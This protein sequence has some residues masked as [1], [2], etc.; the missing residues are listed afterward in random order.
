MSFH[1]SEHTEGVILGIE[2]IL[3]VMQESDSSLV[4][5]RDIAIGRLIAAW[6][7]VVQEW[8]PNEVEE[9]EGEFAGK[10]KLFRKRKIKDNEKASSGELVSFMIEK[11][12]VT[13]AKIFTKDELFLVVESIDATVP[14]WDPENKTVSQPNLE[15]KK[16]DSRRNK[17]IKIS[18]VEIALALADLGVAGMD[19]P[20]K[21]AEDGKRLFREE[22]LDVLEA[23]KSRGIDGIPTDSQIYFKQRMINWL[24]S[25][26]GFV[27]GRQKRLDAELQV[28]PESARQAVLDLFNKFEDSIG[29]SVKVIASCESM[30]FGELA[31]YM[32]Y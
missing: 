13:G 23:V 24:R 27:Q 28:V 9:K 25:Q 22:N 10:K 30:T 19:G 31:R 16:E 1:N 21:F 14:G 12:S 11:V 5:D 20:E 15:K 6:H 4:S 18:M 29:A 2:T 7:D 3:S 26:S 17:K 32:G 8:E